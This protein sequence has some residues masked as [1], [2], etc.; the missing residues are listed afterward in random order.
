MGNASKY[1]M[2]YVDRKKKKKT[3]KNGEKKVRKFT[4]KKG[5]NWVPLKKRN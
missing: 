4:P 1:L 5:K 2:G 3:L